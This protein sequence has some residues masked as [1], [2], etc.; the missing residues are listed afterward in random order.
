MANKLSMSTKANTLKSL[1]G[2]LKSAEIASLFSFTVSAW[3]K[4]QEKCLQEIISQIGSGPFI[5][6]SSCSQEDT[7]FSSNAG[8]FLSVLNVDNKGLKKAIVSV[9][10]SYSEPESNDE[11][12]IQPML[13]NTIISG[14]ALSHD[15]NTCAPYR[16]INWHKGNDTTSVTN[17]ASDNVTWQYAA[18]APKNLKTPSDEYALVISLIDELSQIYEE[19]PLDIEFAITRANKIN[20]LWLLQVRP[21]ILQYS[22]ETRAKQKKRLRIIEKNLQTRMGPHPFLRGNRTIYGV[23]P[24]WNPAEIIGIRP[25]PLALSLYRDLITDNIWA[26]QRHNYGYR[27]LRGFPLLTDFFGLPY[28]DVRLSFNSFIPDGLDEALAEKLVDYYIDL[29]QAKPTLHDKIEFEIVFSCYTLDL[30]ERL[31]RL[32]VAGFSEE[33][34]DKI[35]NSLRTLTNKILDPE[36][37]L[38]KRDAAKFEVLNERR[39]QLYKSNESALGIVYWLLEDGKRYGTLPFAGLARAGFIAVQML[40][41][42]VNTGVFSKDEHDEF[43]QSISTVS[44]D[45]SNDLL[46]LEKEAFIK[47]YGHLRPGTY[48]ILSLR[49]DEDPDLYFNWDENS[50]APKKKSTFLLRENQRKKIDSLLKTNNLQ[51]SCDN[52]INFISKGI[53]LREFAKFLFTKNLSDALSIILKFGENLGFDRSELAYSNANLYKELFIKSQDEKQKLRQNIQFGKLDYEETLKVS[54]PTLITKPSDVWSF[55]WANSV[56]NFITQKQITAPVSSYQHLHKLSGAIVYIPNADPGFD[57]LFSHPIAGLITAWGGVNSHMAIRAGELGL[58]A[59][60]GAGEIQYQKW[61]QAQILY[62]DCAN[63]NVRVIK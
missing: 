3:Q 12:L 28:I 11:V 57:W 63:K 20:R 32:L 53:E 34:L 38:W 26:Y 31:E 33:E 18:D 6:R 61:S 47:K 29:L 15:P 55:K 56:P 2:R 22:P 44:T 41:S 5:V 14:V 13:K 16:I 7:K 54:L 1:D 30:P 37:G 60:I 24:D 21:L 40:K 59:V 42:L 27:N 50:L 51:I 58:P 4:D 48:D 23:M 49:Y 52:L 39:E 9:I 8:K 17:G 36:D 19:Q 46:S 62:I 25:K 35:S 43:L 45:L 10:N